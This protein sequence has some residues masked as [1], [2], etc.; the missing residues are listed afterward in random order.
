MA[1]EAA[2]QARATAERLAREREEREFA[3]HYAFRYGTSGPGSHS[4]G[5]SHSSAEELVVVPEPSFGGYRSNQYGG[6]EEEE[7]EEGKWNDEEEEDC[8]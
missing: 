1:E 5:P 7:E 8:T 2:A 3:S 4:H 6:E